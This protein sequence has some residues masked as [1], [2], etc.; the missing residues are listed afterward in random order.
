MT[1]S[2]KLQLT[3]RYNALIERIEEI[4]TLFPET[5]NPTPEADLIGTILAETRAEASTLEL[6]LYKKREYIFS[7]IGGG[8]NTVR[9]FTVEEAQELAATLYGDK[10][11]KTSF[12]EST[13]EDMRNMLS[14]FY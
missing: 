14:L 12:R 6:E 8:W 11:S 13:P 10:I 2:E 4:E 3:S 9:T 5:E 7:F 1:R